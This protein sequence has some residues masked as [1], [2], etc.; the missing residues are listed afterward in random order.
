MKFY[1]RWLKRLSHELRII[2]QLRIQH[3]VRRRI[4]EKCHTTRNMPIAT[5]SGN[6]TQR[7]VLK[8]VTVLTAQ[9]TRLG[10]GD[11]TMREWLHT[12]LG[13]QY[14]H[15]QWQWLQTDTHVATCSGEQTSSQWGRLTSDSDT[16]RGRILAVN[17]RSLLGSKRSCMCCTINFIATKRIEIAHKCLHVFA[18]FKYMS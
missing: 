3:T 10:S 15:S 17:R 2:W 13:S 1:R 7:V 12:E 9:S 18:L 11:I 14:V 6:K 8:L 4:P 5:I 16:V